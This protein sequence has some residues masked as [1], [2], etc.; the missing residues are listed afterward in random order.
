MS[1]NDFEQRP[2]ETKKNSKLK[3]DEREQGC[4]LEG[5]ANF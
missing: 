3:D 5:S 2:T 4:V 1:S